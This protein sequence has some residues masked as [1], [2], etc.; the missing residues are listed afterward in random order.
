MQQ[1]HNEANIMS[2]L[3][4]KLRDKLRNLTQWRIDPS[5]I[6][7]P[8]STPEIR[9]GNAIVSQALL[10]GPSDPRGAVKESKHFISDGPSSDGKATPLKESEND[11]HRSEA[12]QGVGYKDKGED[13]TS[14]RQVRES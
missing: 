11:G 1:R 9:G 14:E 6:E 7:F 4:A 8:G 3:N 13:Q 5:L 2:E 10:T 12:K